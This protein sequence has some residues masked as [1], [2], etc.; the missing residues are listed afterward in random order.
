MHTLCFLISM[1]KIKSSW[2]NFKSSL[3]K[4]KNKRAREGYLIACGLSQV[5][6]WMLKLHLFLLR[7]LPTSG[8]WADLPV[9]ILAT[10]EVIQRGWMMTLSPERDSSW[11]MLHQWVALPASTGLESALTVIQIFPV[12]HGWPLSRSLKASLGTYRKSRVQHD[13]ISIQ[14]PELS[15]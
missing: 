2:K 5:K 4:S 1:I 3:L 9:W 7:A 8:N 13:K 14:F 10:P 15:R 6:Q 11:P 12:R